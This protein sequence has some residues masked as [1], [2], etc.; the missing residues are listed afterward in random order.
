[1]LFPRSRFQELGLSALLAG[2]AVAGC[3]GD[4]NG[5]GNTGGTGLPAS[6]TY[7]GLYATNSGVTGALNITFAS[8]VAAPPVNRSNPGGPFAAGTA[9]IEANGTVEVGGSSVPI[10][11]TLTNDELAMTGAGDL[12]IAGTLAD[13]V[14]TGTFTAGS[15]SGSI[16]AAASSEGT[17]SRNYCGSFEGTVAGSGDPDVGTFSAVIAGTVIHGIA[18]GDGGSADNFKGTATPSGNGGTFTIH[19]T[20]GEGTL[21]VTDG[22][23]N[24][25]STSGHYATKLNGAT[26]AS[27]SFSGPIGCHQA[28]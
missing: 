7:V 2:L 17:P 27:G 10:T 6:T 20:V 1:M 26:V 16:T 19:Q 24:G 5:G 8:A 12:A 23:Y 4:S 21:D 22:V 3:G 11:G 9:P 28:Q 25:E 18:V 14:I 15:E 13:G